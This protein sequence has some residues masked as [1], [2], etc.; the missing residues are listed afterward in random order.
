MPLDTKGLQNGGNYLLALPWLCWI[1]VLTQPLPS[2]AGQWFPRVFDADTGERIGARIYVESVDGLPFT[3]GEIGGGSAVLYDVRRGNSVEAHTTVSDKMTG[4][5]LPYGKYWVRVERG[6]EYVP[7]TFPISFSGPFGIEDSSFD[8]DSGIQLKRWINMA[9][10]GWYSGDTH[11]HRSLRELPNLLLAE[12]LNVALPL[13]YWVTEFKETPLNNSRPKPRESPKPGL[14]KVDETHVIWPVNTEYEI[15]TVGLKQHTLGAVFALNHREPFDLQAHPVKA[16]AEAAR[17]QGA[18]LDLDKHNWPW[19]MMLLPLMDVDLYELTNNHLWRT[20]FLFKDWYPEYFP[21]YLGGE[22]KRQSYSENEWM[23]W[24]FANYYA[25]LNCGFELAPSGGTASGVHP[26]PLGFGR[27]YVH[28]GRTFDFDRWMQGLERGRSFVTTGPMLEVL[29][30]GRLPGTRF[31]A[32]QADSFELGI[33][34]KASALQRIT[35]VEIVV[36][37]DIVATIPGKAVYREPC[38]VEFATSLKLAEGSWV[39]VRCF[40]E[41]GEKRRRFA[42]TGPVYISFD[43]KPLR[44]KRKEVEYL[45]KRVADE[46]ERHR[47]VL[48]DEAVEEYEQALQFYQEKLREAR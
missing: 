38:T 31:R 48:P 39:A 11:V 33:K 28:T 3:F 4:A 5:G 10:A 43:D 24:G 9:E 16:V 14:I 44:P 26:V 34:G 8:D 46:I 13:T 17:K 23:D 37:G 27:V 40:T 20:E 41:H 32:E 6:K 25:L 47:G 12:D 45:V 35:E 7:Q 21:S 29:F 22:P 18:I 19:S 15:F 36:N 42:H 2:L 30:N 1:W